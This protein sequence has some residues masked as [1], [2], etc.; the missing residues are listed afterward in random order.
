MERHALLMD[1]KS[2]FYKEVSFPPKDQYIQC[3]IPAA[4]FFNL[5]IYAKFLWKNQGHRL[6]KYNLEK[7]TQLEK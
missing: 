1:W 3:K 5:Q 2:P 7:R 4:F 6:S